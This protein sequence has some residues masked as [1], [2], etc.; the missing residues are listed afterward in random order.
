MAIQKISA[1]DDLAP[2]FETFGV[3]KKIA[4]Q[5]LY[6]ALGLSILAFIFGG[7]LNRPGIVGDLI[8]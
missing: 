4:K 6:I 5:T 1:N 8:F 3:M 7:G 2:D